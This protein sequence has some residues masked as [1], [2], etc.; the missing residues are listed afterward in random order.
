MQEYEGETVDSPGPAALCESPPNRAKGIAGTGSIQ[1]MGESNPH[2]WN[3]PTSGKI[4]IKDHEI[5]DRWYRELLDQNLVGAYRF[6]LDGA[7]L[8]VNGAM[9][10]M[11]GY[12][13]DDSE[14]GW[15]AADLNA[16][17]AARKEWIR[18]LLRD[19]SVTNHVSRWR[20]KNGDG[21]WVLENSA[22]VDES[23]SRRVILG[24]A[25]DFTERKT[26]EEELEWM[27]YH[28]SLTRLA[29]RRLLRKMARK[30]I[31][32]ADR[33]GS[34]VAMLYLDLV[35]FKRINDV[36]G[37]TFGDRVLTQVADRFRKRV[38]ATDTLAR[39]GGD[40]F[41]LLLVSPGGAED[42]RTAARNLQACLDKPFLVGGEKF[43]LDA[44]IGIA[45]YPD[46]AQDCDELLAHAD[47]GMHRAKSSPSG[48][49]MYRAVQNDARQAS[50]VIEEEL[51]QALEK[52][53]LVLFYQPVFDL[54]DGNVVGAEA[55]IR[56]RH[57]HRG[58]LTAEE[59]VPLAEHAG[60]IPQVDRWVLR[61]AIRQIAS[62]GRRA[63][64][65]TAVNVSPETLN[66]PHLMDFIGKTLRDEAVEPERMAIEVPERVAI[67]KPGRAA[68]VL[69]HLHRSGTKIVIDEFGRGHSSFTYLLHL[70]V[71]L[72]KLDRRFVGGIGNEP[73]F[74]R[75][76]E[77][78]VGLCGGLGVQFVAEGVEN[79]QQLEWLESRNCLMAQGF[80]L[81][82]VV[83]P[84][85]LWKKS[86]A[87][88]RFVGE[89]TE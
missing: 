75:L 28:D 11:L 47:R 82:E 68:D 12:G 24:T 2:L 44:R 78:I 20:R 25:I 58:L 73:A 43:H 83:P 45:L 63:P 62:W 13:R 60:L 55:L 74:E 89:P 77:G 81:G 10:R 31:A 23:V 50:R 56:W 30:A 37:H 5:T 53:E 26:L 9:A 17:F 84:E 57:S 87:A 15:E 54:S 48:I 27:A 7:V 65:W 66:Y 59:F 79:R 4:E 42:A 1:T 38:R 16:R 3:R 39:L 64:A 21:I 72:I 36:L 86:G 14:H 46:H 71:D 8:T 18:L 76:V 40:E 41:A 51:K 29:N 33:L 85:E 88:G 22:V 52:D 67:R 34:R 32:H 19:G 69:E 80:Y 6:A 49:G 35:R 61:S 70:P